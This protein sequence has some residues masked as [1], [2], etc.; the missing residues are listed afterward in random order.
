MHSNSKTVV[1]FTKQTN[2]KKNKQ[3]HVDLLLF[4]KYHSS[5]SNILKN[6]ENALT[7]RANHRGGEFRPEMM[8]TK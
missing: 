8:N 7:I 6:L 4:H 1:G 3:K 2:Q 5:L